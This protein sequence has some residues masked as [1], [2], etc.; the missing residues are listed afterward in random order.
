[1]SL[2]HVWDTLWEAIGEGKTVPKRFRTGFY[3]QPSWNIVFEG[4]GTDSETNKG[5]ILCGLP[6]WSN[7]RKQWY[8]T[9]TLRIFKNT[10][11]FTVILHIHVVEEARL[12]TKINM[13]YG[14]RWCKPA[15]SVSGPPQDLDLEATW[16][17]KYL[18]KRFQNLFTM[19]FKHHLNLKRQ[20]GVE[21]QV[22][23]KGRSL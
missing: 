16:G 1:M 8:D 14:L 19:K 10:C 23:G 3:L 18:P 22:G 11:V 13:F 21:V 17:S 6:L 15:E 4:F 12:K 5:M 20:N 9:A 7:T 2:G